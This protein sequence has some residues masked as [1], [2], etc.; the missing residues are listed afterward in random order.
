MLK[1]YQI[2]GE[3]YYIKNL[4]AYGGMSEVYLGFNKLG[5]QIVLKRLLPKLFKDNSY[6]ENLSSYFDK[7]PRFC[8]D[9]DNGSGWRLPFGDFIKFHV[10]FSYRAT[11]LSKLHR[12]FVCNARTWE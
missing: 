1:P 2:V 8:S 5:D 7:N 11:K 6:I 9:F 4:L 10:S 12:S 3:K